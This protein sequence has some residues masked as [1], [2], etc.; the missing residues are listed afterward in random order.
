MSY[1]NHYLEK[2]TSGLN[3][4]EKTKQDLL[5]EFSDHLFLLKKE[6]LEQ[7]LSDENAEKCAVLDFGE[8]SHIQ[9]ELEKTLNPFNKILKGTIWLTFCVYIWFI[10]MVAF[11]GKFDVLVNHDRGVTLRFD[12][13]IYSNHNLIPLKNIHNEIYQSIFWVST[14]NVFDITFFT[15][16]LGGM[17][18]FIPLGIFLFILFKI[19]T[20]AKAILYVLLV[21][22]MIEGVQLLTGTGTLNVNDVFFYLIGSTIGWFLLNIIRKL[23]LTK[24]GKGHSLIY[25]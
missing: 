13:G 14:R 3:C 6:Y 18:M 16:I 10:V 19:N 17:L 4:D 24:V 8:Q 23:N 1:I 12:W 7:G 5:D 9:S 22:I 11:I 2:L 20:F 21:G 25:R 15:T